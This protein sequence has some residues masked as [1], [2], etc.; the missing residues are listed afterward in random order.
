MVLKHLFF[1]TLIIMINNF[2]SELF[3]AVKNLNPIS[4]SPIPLKI[5]LFSDIPNLRTSDVYPGTVSHPLE[6]KP[7]INI[8][9]QR[10]EAV[11]LHFYVG[12]RDK[13]NETNSLCKV[14]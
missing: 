3:K 12:N 4:I 5:L 14:A 8:V 1:C 7:F 2:F 6:E 10:N 13:N 11:L 9:S